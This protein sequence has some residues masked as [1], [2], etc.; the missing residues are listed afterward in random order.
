M[1][2][3]SQYVVARH[4]QIKYTTYVQSNIG[5]KLEAKFSGDKLLHKK[6]KFVV[7]LKEMLCSTNF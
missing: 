1:Q 2:I 5:Q 3:R 7:C 4:K 6:E